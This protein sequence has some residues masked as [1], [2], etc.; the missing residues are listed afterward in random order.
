MNCRALALRRQE[1]LLKPRK[2]PLSIVVLT[3]KE[4]KKNIIKIL[5]S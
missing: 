2:L 5:D 3:Y 1:E 4:S